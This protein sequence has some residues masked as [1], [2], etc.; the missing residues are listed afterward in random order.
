M[1]NSIKDTTKHVY[2]NPRQRCYVALMSDQPMCRAEGST[3][4]EAIENV[5]RAFA[6]D[7]FPS[8]PMGPWTPTPSR[9]EV[10]A[11]HQ[12]NAPVAA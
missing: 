12:E 8:A 9:A 10:Y 2:W 5:E 11:H 3:P 1:L 7:K 6:Q 4:A